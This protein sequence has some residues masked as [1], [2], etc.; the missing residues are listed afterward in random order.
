M[1][2]SVLLA[3]LLFLALP[4]Q[5][6]RFAVVAK[7]S[8]L[9]FGL[10]ISKPFGERWAARIAFNGISFD[11]DIR[12]TDV[13]YATDIDL[14][15]AGLLLDWHPGGYAFRI[16]TGVFYNGNEARTTGRPTGGNF[17]INGQDYA[18]ADVGSLDGTIDFKAAAPYVGIGFG[19]A[20]KRGFKFTIDIG[21]LYQSAP[22]V[23]LQ[24]GCADPA[25]CSQLQEDV[26]AEAAR[27]TDELSDYRWWPVIGVGIG[28]AF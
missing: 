27:L 4:V 28:W 10:D 13:E 8:T 9:G 12:E 21:A 19:N 15:T 16:S 11:R 7:S 17:R 14:R 23:N 1:R 25:V 2:R 24:V 6:E 22:R 5:A 20:G 26:Q 3:L 18:A